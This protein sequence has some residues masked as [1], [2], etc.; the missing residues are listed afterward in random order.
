MDQGEG[1]GEQELGSFGELDPDST[2]GRHQNV[3]LQNSPLSGSS[4]A[5]G[6]GTEAS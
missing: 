5:A 2:L 1:E 4:P 3:R 6:G